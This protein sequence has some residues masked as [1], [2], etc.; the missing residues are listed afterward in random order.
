M[1]SAISADGSVLFS[2]NGMGLQTFDASMGLIKVIDLDYAG[3]AYSGSDYGTMEM[4]YGGRL[5]L[6]SAADGTISLWG[7][8]GR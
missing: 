3:N 1:G 6:L 8:P 5:L 4:G 7:V 2:G